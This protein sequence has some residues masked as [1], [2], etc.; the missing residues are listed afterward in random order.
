[1]HQNVFVDL[2][3]GKDGTEMVKAFGNCA[4]IAFYYLLQVREYK[5]KNREI[6]QS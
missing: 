2:E 4:V 6:K 5:V 1:M 3:I